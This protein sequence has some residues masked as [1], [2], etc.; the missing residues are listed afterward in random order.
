MLATTS[1]PGFTAFACLNYTLECV[2]KIVI[3]EPLVVVQ[4]GLLNFIILIEICNLLAE[5]NVLS[6][7]FWLLLDILN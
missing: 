4:F 6:S 5:F 2:V 7:D 1:T 3:N